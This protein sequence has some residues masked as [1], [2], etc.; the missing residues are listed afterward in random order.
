MLISFTEKLV[1]LAFGWIECKEDPKTPNK[2]ACLTELHNLYGNEPTDEPWCAIFVWTMVNETCKLFSVEN[3]LPKTKS[4]TSMKERASN[5]GLKVDRTPAPGAIFYY[6]RTGGGHVG[7]VSS[8]EGN[9]L[10]TIEG[11]VSDRVRF[12][13]RSIN[14]HPFH[15]IH[16][17]AMTQKKL[18]FGK[19]PHYALL[20][21][22]GV[23]TALVT[24]RN[25]FRKR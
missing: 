2:S 9:E 20:A 11:N 17:E 15:F 12:G 25:F 6:P 22:T 4:T 21:V 23:A 13:R 16:V 24:W 7:I 1:E 14:Q 10:V 3:K 5:S 18:I 8:I 19:A